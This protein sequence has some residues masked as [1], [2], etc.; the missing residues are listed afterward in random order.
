MVRCVCAV[1]YYSSY[2]VGSI[3]TN[4]TTK[5]ISLN[6]REKLWKNGLI[7]NYEEADSDC[8]QCP[9]CAICTN[10]A[11]PRARG[12]Y[13][14][15][16]KDADPDK[17]PRMLAIATDLDFEL[18]IEGNTNSINIYKCPQGSECVNNGTQIC[19]LHF[20]GILCMVRKTYY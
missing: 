2:A 6:C 17:P 10:D 9:D 4:T 15:V 3:L 13:A 7:G 14:L 1:D 8:L 5:S 20:T 19:G 12:N 11:L 18:Q 16:I